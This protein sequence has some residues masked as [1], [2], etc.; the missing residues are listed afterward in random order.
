MKLK[1]SKRGFIRLHSVNY[2]IFHAK[3]HC[4]Y[5]RPD[6]SRFY[7]R[8]GPL[9][10]YGKTNGTDARR[11][12]LKQTDFITAYAPHLEQTL[13]EDDMLVKAYFEGC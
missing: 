5:K 6:L 1:S 4:L 13:P 3:T 12:R 10:G 11:Q 7:H 8:L 2:Y 9:P